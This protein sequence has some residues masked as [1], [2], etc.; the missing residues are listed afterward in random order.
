M[1][2]FTHFTS[3]CLTADY[4]DMIPDDHSQVEWI[5]LI[6]CDTGASLAMIN[7]SSDVWDTAPP[8]N[9]FIESALENE[10]VL[11]FLRHQNGAIVTYKR[12]EPNG[13]KALN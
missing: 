3:F 12:V 9:V 7:I 10:E 8:F 11:E 1:T 5:V 2:D 4:H 13:P 6:G